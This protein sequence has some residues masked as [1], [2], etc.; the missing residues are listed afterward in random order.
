MSQQWWV[1][2]SVLCKVQ[3]TPVHT[4]LGIPYRFLIRVLQTLLR[5]EV[6]TAYAVLRTTQRTSHTQ[7]I[8]YG[9]KPSR[10][11][12]CG[13][14]T[15]IDQRTWLSA[16]PEIIK[17]RAMNVPGSDGHKLRRTVHKV[18][19]RERAKAPGKKILSG[20]PWC[21]SSVVYL[22]FRAVPCGMHPRLL[23]WIPS[24]KLTEF[25]SL[26]PYKPRTRPIQ[27]PYK[28]PHADRYLVVFPDIDL[29]CISPSLRFLVSLS[30]SLLSLSHS[31]SSAIVVT[32][33]FSY[34]Q[35]AF[36]PPRSANFLWSWTGSGPPIHSMHLHSLV[37]QTLH[38][39]AAGRSLSR[40]D[41]TSTFASSAPRLS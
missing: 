9:C 19:R 40:T 16:I 13:P 4:C 15:I 36:R 34:C 31:R 12:C 39:E 33:P 11:A 1:V 20:P 30:L 18:L 7:W 27:A 35:L 6:S 24:R 25:K 3:Y 10:D 28:V 41:P 8:T 38:L 21:T 5:S 14:L 22:D 23:G 37:S 17:E 32:L 2:Q 29:A 26:A